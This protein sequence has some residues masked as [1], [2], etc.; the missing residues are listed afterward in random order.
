M[1]ALALPTGFSSILGL[2]L[3]SGEKKNPNHHG[4][5]AAGPHTACGKPLSTPGLGGF[6][7]EV[8][9]A[10]VYR[11]SAVPPPGKGQRRLGGGVLGPKWALEMS[12]S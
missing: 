6:P 5:R 11:A 2:A 10:G 12:C 8:C 7:Q 9:D 3:L 4:C 1:A